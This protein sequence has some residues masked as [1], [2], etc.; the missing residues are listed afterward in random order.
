MGKIW[1][2][3]IMKTLKMQKKGFAFL[4][5]LVFLAFGI[6]MPGKAL[7]ASEKAKTSEN[8]TVSKKKPENGWYTFPSGRKRY[9]KNGKYL[10]GL[11]T[12]GKK[13]YLFNK[14]GIMLT[15]TKKI[16]NKVYYLNK[17]GVLMG[18]KLGKRY[19][20]RNGKCLTGLQTKG[21]KTYLFSKKGIMLTGVVKRK[22]KTYYLDD[23]GV[24]QV[25]KLGNKYYDGKGK[26]MSQTATQNF[27]TLEKAKEIV[28]QITN[29]SMTDAQ[30]MKICFDWVIRKP[31]ATRRVFS[32]VEGW[33]A[34][35]A[36]DHFTYGSGNC[37]SDAAAFAYLAKAIG[38]E[39][40]NVCVDCDGRGGRGHSW[41]EVNGLCYDPLFAEAKNYA[42]YFG[43]RY[44]VYPL[45][46]ILRIP[47]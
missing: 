25:K 10:T 26:R 29:S 24:L 37:F 18:K 8:T 20:D 31:Y 3:K 23:K 36:Q 32:N 30:K 11:K 9:Y 7:A 38:Y 5:L 46:A 12:I 13:T 34:V 1:K 41:A 14:K 27:I 45:S 33:P 40:V 17:K 16:K 2:G 28:G 19:Y 4:L 42:Q 44:G 47:I 43:T 35:Y 21:G 39:N 15:G 6:G 22:N